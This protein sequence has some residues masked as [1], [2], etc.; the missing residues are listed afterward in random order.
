MKASAQSI[1]TTDDLR[2]SLQLVIDSKK[3]E[4]AK[5]ENALAWLD[6]PAPT[7]AAE[8]EKPQRQASK[9]PGRKPKAERTPK[10]SKK[11]PRTTTRREPADDDAPRARKGHVPKKGV[12]QLYCATLQERQAKT[13][14]L[15]A[16]G[17]RR[18]GPGEPLT[19]GTYDVRPSGDE[20]ES[21]VVLWRAKAEV[22][23][24]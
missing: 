3:H 7:A 2:S 9:K 19:A 18:I 11:S 10:K 12:E 8:E 24:E 13:G 1:P 14:E 17:Y 20:D 23:G 15:K 5:L 4:L 21:C 16:D 6:S 22:D